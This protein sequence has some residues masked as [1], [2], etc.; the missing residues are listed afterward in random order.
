[1]EQQVQDLLRNQKPGP[2]AQQPLPAVREGT[3]SANSSASGVEVPS[4]GDVVDEDLVSLERADTLIELY[5][6]EMMPHFPF[7]YIAPHLTGRMM[8]FDKPFLF[9][10]ILSVSCF[11][12]PVTQEKLVHGFKYLVSEK[13]L[14]GGDDN[15]SLEYVQGLMVVLAWYV[16][17][18]LEAN[19][20]ALAHYPPGTTI[21][22]DR[23]T[24]PNI[25]SW[26]FQ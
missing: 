24:T 22:R 19:R 23:H 10:A 16:I 4:T 26:P 20:S 1:L 17:A 9:L 13:V 18:A 3:T 14:M 5:K 12:D 25:F 21:T 6:S 2:V 8:R 15:L 7:I 11:H